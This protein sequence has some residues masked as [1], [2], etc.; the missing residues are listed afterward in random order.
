MMKTT[1]YLR[2][3]WTIFLQLPVVAVVLVLFPH[4]AGVVV[5]VDGFVV[6]SS[7]SLTS[8]PSSSSS[9]STYNHHQYSY[10]SLAFTITSSS[11]VRF[12]IKSQLYSINNNITN[13][14][15]NSNNKN[16]ME[17]QKRQVEEV[18]VVDFFK[19]GLLANKEEEA[20][21]LASKKIRS[22]ANLGFSKPTTTKAALLKKSQSPPQRRRSSLIRPK[23]WAWGGA[24]E[25]AIQDKPNYDPINNPNCPDPWVSLSDFYRLVDD[26]TADTIFVALAGGR[27][28]V[29]RDVA[30]QILQEWYQNGSS[31]TLDKDAFFQTVRR[32]Q[33]D[34][35]WGWGSFISIT[36]LALLGIIFPTNP[37]QMALVHALDAV[38]VVV[39][40]KP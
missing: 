40:T 28:F 7:S 4:Y 3:R 16:I 23:Y 31:T 30:E 37:L 29:E 21:K 14:R 9:S 26:E 2:L 25:R 34:F 38:S 22:L 20:A 33:Q 19:A 15:N 12:A 36:G 5:W 17:D 1:Y 35:V 13:K 6:G 11:P 10:P 27:A 32:G 18:V 39:A 24:E 8:S